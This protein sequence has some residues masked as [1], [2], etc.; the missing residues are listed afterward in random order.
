MKSLRYLVALV[1]TAIGFGCAEKKP[2]FDP[3]V[4]LKIVVH[5]DGTV[6]V[7]ETATP[8]Q[9]IPA[10]LASLA[11]K[12]GVV[13]FYRANPQ[14][15]PPPNSMETLKLVMAARRPIQLFAKEDFSEYVDANGNLRKRK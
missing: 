14:G 12:K 11:E 2:D 4:V 1:L 8:L 5:A 9:D 10:K 7:G 13:W 3:S 15:D 6:L